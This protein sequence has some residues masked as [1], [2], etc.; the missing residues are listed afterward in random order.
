[1][2]GASFFFDGFIM[3]L[4]STLIYQECHKILSSN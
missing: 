3:E 1:M 4:A 2:R